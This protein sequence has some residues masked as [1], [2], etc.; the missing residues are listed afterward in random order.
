[1]VLRPDGSTLLLANTSVSV[2]PS[3]FKALPYDTLRDLSPVV[4]LSPSPNV[5]LAHAPG[6]DD[7]E[8]ETI[9]RSG[10]SVTMCPST[11]LKEGSGLGERKLPELLAR[12]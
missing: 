7:S 3:L 10:A 11:T 12:G 1:M 9:A 4:Y 8:V 2:N 6:I 5:L